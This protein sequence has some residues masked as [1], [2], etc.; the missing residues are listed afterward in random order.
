[1]TEMPELDIRGQNSEPS[2]DSIAY[3]IG[4]IYLRLY[5]HTGLVNILQSTSG[6]LAAQGLGKARRSSFWSISKEYHLL[7]VGTHRSPW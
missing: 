5:K 3:E 7:D 4:E 6:N 1:M 2:T